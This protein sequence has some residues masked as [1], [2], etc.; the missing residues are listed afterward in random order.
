MP[1]KYLTVQNEPE[2]VQTWDSCIYTAEEEGAFVV[3]YL[4]PALEAAGLQISKDIVGVHFRFLYLPGIG[5][6]GVLHA[7]LREK[8]SLM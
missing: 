3:D 1:V 5:K 8:D 6:P 7:A 2:A 4:K